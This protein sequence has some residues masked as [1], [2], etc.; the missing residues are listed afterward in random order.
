[1]ATTG[2]LYLIPCPLG[3]GATYT[4]PQYLVDIIHQLDYFIVERG[5]TA[6]QFLKTTNLPKPLQ[7]LTYFE[8]N[9]HDPLK[10]IKEFL[11]PALEGHNIGLIS[12]AGAPGVAD[13]GADVVRLAHSL[14]IPVHPL[15]GPSSILLALMASGMNGQ[16]FCFRG[17][18]SPKKLDLAKDLRQLEQLSA[19]FNQTQIFIETPYRN[20]QVVE[21][22]LNSLG[23][24]TYFGI[25]TDL[26]LPSQYIKTQQIHQWLRSE[27]PDINKR[28]T[29]FLIYS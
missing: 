14:D 5:K 9:K 3:E 10:G 28:P 13:P 24:Q 16:E 20:Q 1:M 26:T 6:R 12:E 25:A 29:V 17:Y 21:T 22:A 4:L 2:T 19:K 18:L 7:E 23:P 8:L 27:L 15:V 11:E